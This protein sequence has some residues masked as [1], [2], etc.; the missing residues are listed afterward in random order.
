MALSLVNAQILIYVTLAFFFGVGVYAGRKGVVN[1]DQFL[2][3]R[4]SQGW[5]GLGLNLFA[6]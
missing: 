5:F 1:M 2:T 3:A 4:G 6:A